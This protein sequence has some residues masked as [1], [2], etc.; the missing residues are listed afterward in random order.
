[1]SRTAKERSPIKLALI[2]VA[3]LAVIGLLQPT[4]SAWLYKGENGPTAPKV[5][6]NP[7]QTPS[8]MNGSA[9]NPALMPGAD[10][11]KAHLEKNGASPA[12]LAKPS[13]ATQSN[14]TSPHP[15][16]ADP[17]KAFLEQQKQLGKEVGVSPFGK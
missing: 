15:A 3:A 11:F 4:V 8:K 5:E 9:T 13:T 16:G 1:M 6:L 2:M 7:N 10:P 12:P 17:F 14:S